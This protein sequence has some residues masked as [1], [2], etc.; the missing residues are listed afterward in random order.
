MDF[1]SSAKVTNLDRL[2]KLNDS[3][4]TKER[5]VFR[6]SSVLF[7]LAKLPMQASVLDKKNEDRFGFGAYSIRTPSCF[8]PFPDF[9]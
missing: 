9:F 7:C 4:P 2:S 6:T 5:I 3:K 8:A 1:S